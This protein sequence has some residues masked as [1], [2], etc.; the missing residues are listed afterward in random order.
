MGIYDIF[1]VSEILS[2]FAMSKVTNKDAIYLCIN[3]VD[4]IQNV[5]RSTMNDSDQIYESSQNIISSLWRI[6]S[7]LTVKEDIHKNNFLVTAYD[8]DLDFRGINIKNCHPICNISLIQ[9]DTTDLEE[10]IN[11]DNSALFFSQKLIQD[12]METNKK[13]NS[14]VIFAIFFN[15]ILFIRDSLDELSQVYMVQITHFKEKFTDR[16]TLKLNVTSAENDNGPLHC[17]LFT[18]DSADW[19]INTVQRKQSSLC[20]FYQ[21]GYYTILQTNYAPNVT[22][23][24]ET[25]QKDKEIGFSEKIYRLGSLSYYYQSFNEF[26]LY[27]LNSILE[28]SSEIDVEDLNIFATLLNNIVKIEREILIGA[29]YKGNFI[30]VILEKLND[31]IEAFPG[32]YSSTDGQYFNLLIC[33]TNSS[34]SVTINE[35]SAFCNSR[36]SE[37]TDE[38]GMILLTFCPSPNEESNKQCIEGKF[39]VSIFRENSFFASEMNLTD[40][41]IGFSI[42]PLLTYPNDLYISYQELFNSSNLD[43]CG[44]WDFMSN[45]YDF[46]MWWTK[47]ASNTS[48]QNW[49]MCKYQLTSKA[50]YYSLVSNYPIHPRDLAQL[51]RNIRDEKSDPLGKIE[52]TR[53]ALQKFVGIVGGTHVSLISQI[54]LDIQIES[55]ENLEDYCYIIN[56][57]MDVPQHILASS[58][59]HYNA[60]DY[61]LK[62]LKLTATIAE[63]GK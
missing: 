61:I 18:K 29:Q 1:L 58:Q 49:I 4:S 13:N 54:L 53:Y 44:Y 62:S 24:L 14:V 45:Q 21:Q 9:A 36:R 51:F 37:G 28:K 60:T 5:N 17:A 25:L 35:Y 52:S 43:L 16:L 46:G 15:N 33:D 3:I 56:S 2:N 30:S 32:Q 42:Y 19:T 38:D 7:E 63:F 57:L 31:L 12:I 26:E 8:I 40:T 11:S 20:H 59:Q 48:Q 50:K 47:S 23:E 55:T 10:N 34:N 22:Y 6:L 41:V 39:A 27:I